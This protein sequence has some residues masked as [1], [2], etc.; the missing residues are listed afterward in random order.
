[1]NT[2]PNVVNT[3]SRETRNRL[4]HDSIAKGDEIRQ[5]RRNPDVWLVSSAT[6]PNVWYRVR[7]GRHCG[8]QA[9]AHRGYCRHLVRLSFELHQ[10]KNATETNTPESIADCTECC[11]C[12]TVYSPSGGWKCDA[13]SGSGRVL[14]AV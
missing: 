1:M 9:F 12:G 6:H 3:L 14:A 2:I 10:M 4:L 7:N 11:G 13:C 5:D 8:C